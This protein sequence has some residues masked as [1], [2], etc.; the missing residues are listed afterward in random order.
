[1]KKIVPAVWFQ[2]KLNGPMARVKKPAVLELLEAE[3]AQIGGG[4]MA[5]GG[6]TD[7]CSNCVPDDCLD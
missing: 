7:S 2:N 3:L 4:M 5:V 1:M 6:G